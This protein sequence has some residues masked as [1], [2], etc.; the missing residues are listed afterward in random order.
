MHTCPTH[1]NMTIT[2]CCSQSAFAMR[3]EMCGVDRIGVVVP[4]DQQRSGLHRGCWRMRGRVEQWLMECGEVRDCV[5]R[6]PS[7]VM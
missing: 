3:L 4:G 6:S 2:A 1:P 7:V 5:G